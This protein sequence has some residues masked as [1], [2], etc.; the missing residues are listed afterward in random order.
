MGVQRLSR[1]NTVNSSANSS[2]T[3]ALLYAKQDDKTVPIFLID[4]SDL[5]VVVGSSR[6]SSHSFK[7]K[8]FSLPYAMMFNEYFSRQLQ[9][10]KHSE[11]SIQ[12]FLQEYGPS[13]CDC[14]GSASYFHIISRTTY[15]SG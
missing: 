1:T 12:Q 6:R 8:Y 11:T 15:I 2:E 14:Y 3:W 10:I 7:R 5:F 4:R 13:A 9:P